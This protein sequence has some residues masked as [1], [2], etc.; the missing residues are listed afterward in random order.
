MST[1][2]PVA[3]A[4]DAGLNF[5]SA[6]EYTAF[7]EQF[8][9]RTLPK[10]RWTHRAHLVTGLWHL[11]HHS[12]EESLNLLRE[13]IRAYNVAVG[14]VN[15]DT[16]GYHETLTQFYVT[17]INQWLT[18][19]TALRTDPPELARRLLATRFA[20]KDFPLEF[21]SKEL[22]FSI[23]ARA[24]GVAPDLKQIDHFNIST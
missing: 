4:A 10:P 8:V 3:P 15:T 6:A 14:G 9:A 21:Y 11:L 23:E 13:R 22:L 2:S 17:G 1:P 19:H 20:D 16:A 12:P 18:E 7:V 5:Q 24:N